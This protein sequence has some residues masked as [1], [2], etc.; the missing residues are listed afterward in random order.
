MSARQVDVFFYG[1]LMD[2]DL[3]RQSGAEPANPRRAYVAEFALRIGQR[4]TLV[5]SHG[6]RA[7]GMV[8]ALTHAEL[9]QLYDAPGLE[10]YRPEAVLAQVIEGHPVP[11]LCYNLLQAPEPHERNS[12]YA[13]R[14]K[15]VLTKLGFPENYIASV[16]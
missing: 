16:S 10:H 15:A 8:I 14:L 3:L 9:K 7:Y 4:A 6:A 13:L 12:D 5:P 1:L 2:V 11:A